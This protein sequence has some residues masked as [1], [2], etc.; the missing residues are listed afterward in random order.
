MRHKLLLLPWNDC[1]ITDQILAIHITVHFPSPRVMVVNILFVSITLS[2][3]RL[4]GCPYPGANSGPNSCCFFLFFVPALKNPSF[5]AF[6]VLAN[7][8]RLDAE[9]FLE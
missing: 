7:A 4:L 2:P 8:L 5:L 3:P 1:T 6:S 9:L